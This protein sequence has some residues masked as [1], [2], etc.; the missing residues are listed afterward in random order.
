[1]TCTVVEEVNARV[2]ALDAETAE[3]L[4][5]LVREMAAREELRKDRDSYIANLTARMRELEAQSASLN[6]GNTQ[7]ALAEIMLTDE[8]SG[9]EKKVKELEA[10][11]IEKNGSA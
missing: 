2:K 5:P 4:A 11:L 8:I 9:L 7:N 6:K 3:E 1:M 10:K